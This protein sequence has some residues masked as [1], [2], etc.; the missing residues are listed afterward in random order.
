[1]HINVN[2]N[3][4]NSLSVSITGFIFFLLGRISFPL[5]SCILNEKNSVQERSE[6]ILEFQVTGRFRPGVL[7][8]H[9]PEGPT[10]RAGVSS[11]SVVVIVSIPEH[12]QLLEVGPVS[13]GEVVI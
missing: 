5:S 9:L 2:T 6:P 12:F 1:M 8:N 13:D 7:R 4:V 3:H 11:G 10:V